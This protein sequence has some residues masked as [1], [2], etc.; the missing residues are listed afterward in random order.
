[1]ELFLPKPK[2]RSERKGHVNYKVAEFWAQTIT[3]LMKDHTVIVVNARENQ[4]WRPDL[5]VVTLD[6][7]EAFEYHHRAGE[8]FFHMHSS[9]GVHD[10]FNQVS[11][12]PNKREIVMRNSSGDTWRVLRDLEPATDDVYQAWIEARDAAGKV[13]T[14]K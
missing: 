10:G 13:E 3:S 1:M 4:G 8:G 7:A 11:I 14:E 12:D 9:Y 2:P 5:E 6:H